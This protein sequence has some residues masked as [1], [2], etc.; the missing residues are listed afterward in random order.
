L[1]TTDVPADA[2]ILFIT[3][4]ERD[5][6]PDQTERVAN[7]LQNG[8]RAIFVMGYRPERFPRVDEVLAS[9]GVRVGDYI[10]IEGS[11]AHFYRNFPTLLLP[12]FVP[13]EITMP[14]LERG[15]IPLVFQ[16]TGVDTLDLR[17][18]STVISPVMRS[19]AQSYGRIHPEEGTPISRIAEDIDG[20]FSLAVTAEDTVWGSRVVVVSSDSVLREDYNEEMGGTNWSFLVN[21]LNWLREEPPRVFI[22]GRTPPAATPL[23]MNTAQVGM[24]A[25]VSVVVLPLFFAIVGIV[26]W[27]RRRNA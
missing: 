17:R 25:F 6:S 10:I 16:A 18:P 26:V 4:P 19:S 2:D 21:S 8:G 12:D 24:V 13:T 20:P 22:R 27:L 11:P 1:L 5:W 7:Y 9:L 15:F 14:L 23:T 3:M